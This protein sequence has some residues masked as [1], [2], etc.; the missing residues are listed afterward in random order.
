MIKKIH[1]IWISDRN[2]PPGEYVANQMQKLKH[3]YSDYEYTL[4]D[5]EMCRDQVRSMLGAEGVRLYDS[6]N[7]YAF[8]SDFARYCILYQHGGFY[9]DSVICPEFKLEFDNFP[10]MYRATVGMWH[11]DIIDNGV[12]LVG[13][14]NHP[15][16]KDALKLCLKNIHQQLY[17][18]GPLSIT[19]PIMLGKLKKTYD[20]QFGRARFLESDTPNALPRGAFFEDVLHWLYKPYGSQLTDLDCT[21]TN[22]YLEMW[23]NK[24]VFNNK[25]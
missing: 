15:F 1:Q 5:N 23:E 25:I 6:L 18:E 7:P 17:G 2:T 8:R 16:L 20:I 19:G 14:P 24:T 10:V 4:Y 12:L 11:H 22:S 21:G 9:F 13:K 3:M